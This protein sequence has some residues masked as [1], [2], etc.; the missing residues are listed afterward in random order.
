MG[1][2]SRC[3]FFLVAT[4]VV[5][6][7]L[8]RNREEDVIIITFPLRPY[9]FPKSKQLLRCRRGSSEAFVFSHLVPSSGSLALKDEVDGANALM[10]LLFRILFSSEL[11]LSVLLRFRSCSSVGVVKRWRRECRP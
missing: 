10:L 11:V 7:L 4:S 5:S 8:S 3:C 9:L 1:T 6:V 2:G